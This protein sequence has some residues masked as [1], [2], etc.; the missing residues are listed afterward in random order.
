MTK[1]LKDNRTMKRILTFILA[2]A[3]AVVMTVPAQAQEIIPDDPQLVKGRLDNGMTYYIRHNENPEGCADFYIIHNVGALQEEDNQNGLAHFL[4]HMAFNGTR[5]YPDKGILNFLAK[6]GVRFGYN[7]N[8]YTNRTETVYNIS[9]VPLVRDSFVDSVL[10]VLHD[11]S[12]DISC[13]P[14]ALDAE[15]GVISEEWR[16]KDE[17][18]MRMMTKQN[19]L[20]YK[21]AKHTER[22]VIG[23]LEVINGFKPQEILDFYHKWYRPDLQAIVVVGDFDAGKME[24]KV[25]E[26][27]SDIPAA[28]NPAEKEEYGIPALTEPLFENMLDPQVRY[29]VLKVIN[30][31]P[32]PARKLRNTDAFY[33]DFYARQIVTSILDERMSKDVKSPGSPLTSAVLVTSP[34]SDDFY[35]SLFT[36]SMKSPDNAEDALAFYTRAVQ[37]MLR[38]GFS[39]E[40]FEAAKFKMMKKYRMNMEDFASDVTNQQIV[41]AYKENFL[42]GFTAAFPYDLKEE[43]KIILGSLSYD[44]VKGY[45]QKMFR[46]SEKIYSWCMNEKEEA[47]LPDE[48]RMKEIIAATEAE[49]ISPKFLQ[50]EK[51][52]PAETPEPGLVVKT[53]QM[54]NMGCEEWTLSNGAKVYW[55]QSGPVK[56]NTHLSMSI[57]FDT[58]LKSVPSDKVRAA[59]LVST[60]TQRYAGFGKYDF[61]TLRNS[62]DYA[63]TNV[64]FD[65]GQKSSV[66]SLTTD[67]KSVEKG[68]EF[69]YSMLSEPYFST[70]ADLEKVKQS[71]LR[72]LG[73]KKSNQDMFKKEARSVK[74]AGHPWIADLDSS[75]VAMVDMD[76]VKDVYHRNFGDFRHMTAFIASD[77]PADEV[78]A[79]VGKYIASLD[80]EY[81]VEFSKTAVP[82]PAYKGKVVIDRTYDVETV[83]KAEVSYCFKGKTKLDPENLAIIEIL[84]YIMS[85]RYLQQIREARGGTYHVSFST[86]LDYADNGMF[87]SFVDFQTRPEMVDVLVKDVEEGMSRM[88]EEG[89]EASELEEAKKYLVKH[90]AEKDAANENSL[91]ARKGECRDLIRYGIGHDYD[92][93]AV[94]DGISADDIRRFVSRLDKGD[95]FVTIYRE[96]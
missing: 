95:K 85:N 16:R 64:S 84:D 15:R 28:E 14:E 50:Y 37:R 12:C 2:A 57:Y 75:D 3:A 26:M 31:Q 53:R 29:Y 42:R 10:M 41:N 40:E 66:I 62:P 54:K 91:I 73:K 38:Y 4:E 24:Q 71:E 36:F 60:Y 88:A 80:G 49:D 39:E 83:P 9:S 22:S 43:Q 23:T 46:D 51:I 92:Y 32:F 70:D 74:Y 55:V 8:A 79:L 94:I 13:E 78:K 34:Y 72:Y 45:E 87:E 1:K 52:V 63:G 44:D 18:R 86:A 96:Q 35:I 59:R 25:R 89:P 65:F 19:D 6:D 21:G 77:L 48:A 5:H 76:F 93:E 58:G 47:G 68:F 30:K 17:P 11:W 56:S 69:V 27:F 67:G 7:V 20:I 81:D 33:K 61:A 82:A 90:R